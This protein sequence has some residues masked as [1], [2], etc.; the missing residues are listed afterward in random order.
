[1]LGVEQALSLAPDPVAAAVEDESGDALAGI[2]AFGSVSGSPNQPFVPP[3]SMF[4][5]LDDRYSAALAIDKA[6]Q[7]QRSA[8]HEG[9]AT[10]IWSDRV[11]PETALAL[12]TVPSSNQPKRRRPAPTPLSAY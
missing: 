11:Q 8:L 10:T 7:R 6:D 1:M 4:I 12:T 5:W 9:S 2:E 3:T